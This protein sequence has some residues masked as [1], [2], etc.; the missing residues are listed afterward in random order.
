MN[1]N[2]DRWIKFRNENIDNNCYCCQSKSNL[3]LHHNVYIN[4]GRR[5][6]DL[7]DPIYLNKIGCF[8]DLLPF[9][10]TLCKECHD[11]WH[12]LFKIN[13]I[14]LNI[15]YNIYSPFS[16]E[17]D[18]S[19]GEIYYDELEKNN[20]NFKKSKLAQLYRNKNK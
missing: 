8:D 14:T 7:W 16:N 3:Q 12:K 17:W 4:Y 9:L 18:S 15:K 20:L 1:Y 11:E 2:D 6:A 5:K 19:K 13:Y 10:T